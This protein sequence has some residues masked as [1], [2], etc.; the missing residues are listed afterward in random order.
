MRRHTEHHPVDRRGFTLIE[1]LVVISIIA[2]LIAILMPALAKA[3]E[4][5]RTIQCASQVR[6]LS[7]AMTLYASDNDDTLPN[8]DLWYRPQGSVTNPGNLP[9]IP[10]YLK[11]GHISVTP[12][13]MW[14]PDLTQ[15]QSVSNTYKG[16]TYGMNELLS[17]QQTTNLKKPS[18]T[19][20]VADS[21]GPIIWTRTS[22]AL[23]MG[24]YLFPRHGGAAPGLVDWRNLT[25]RRANV[26]CV[27]GHV[28]L[29]ANPTSLP[30]E[31]W[32]SLFV[33]LR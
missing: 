7:V 2:L 3:R 20:L 21:V 6:Q 5:A 17:L 19:L 25:N 23:N 16:L 30:S 24:D 22:D 14:C 4:Q 8:R 10:A 27:D 15:E 13:I 29:I 28:E 31:E 9:L 11:P 12:W 1:L 32:L 26:L 33:H 18:D